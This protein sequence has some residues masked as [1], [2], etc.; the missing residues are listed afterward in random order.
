MMPEPDLRTAAAIID[1]ILTRFET[2]WF[3]T[4]AERRGTSAPSSP[5]GGIAG[6]RFDRE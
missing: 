5:R 2:W 3:L 4:T 6:R 1:A